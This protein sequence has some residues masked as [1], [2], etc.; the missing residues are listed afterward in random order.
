MSEGDDIQ[1]Q[2]SQGF[3]N[4]PSGPVTQNFNLTITEEQAK[5]LIAKL[6]QYSTPEPPPPNVL[7]DRNLFLPPGSRLRILPNAVFTGREEDLLSVG[8]TLL[9]GEGRAAGIVQAAAATGTGGIGKTQLAVEF[10]YRYGRYFQG[11]HWIQT[12]LDIKDEISTCGLAIGL[13]PWPEKI[14]EQVQATLLAWVV[15]GPR[16]IVLDNAEETDILEEWMPLLPQARLLLTSRRREWPADLGLDLHPLDTLPRQESLLLLRKLAPKLKKNPDEELDPVAKRLGD[17]PLALDLAGRY[18]HDRRRLTPADFL[19]EIEDEGALEHSALKDWTKHNPTQH[20]ANLAK[21]FLRSWEQI[22]RESARQLF[23]A[24]GYCAANTTIPWEVLVLSTGE[25]GNEAEREVDRDLKR[26]DDLGL[27]KLEETGVVVH[28]LLAEFGRLQDRAA[29]QSALPG[30]ADGLAKTAYDLNMSGL[31]DKYKPLRA[32]VEVAANWAERD[33][34]D[35]AGSLWVNSGFHLRAVA[36]Y[37]GARQAYERALRIDEDA[38]GPD[39]PNVATDVNNLGLVLKDQGDLAGARQTFERAL[40]I[41]EAAFGPD[42]PEV[43]TD[44]N[45]LGM[46]LQDLGDLAGARQAYERALAILEKFL[47]PDHPNIQIVKR[48]LNSLG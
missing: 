19:Q 17:L 24:C 15:S 45:N 8:K 23:Q 44:V 40:R 10:C 39:H 4:R 32:H 26:L 22:E 47:S 18:L 30:M 6:P 1:A 14:D 37:T 5:V 31:P 25:E 35:T 46:V 33:H 21:T 27:V 42:H 34:L 36:E 38:F 2:Y 29:E 20:E 12:N 28:P 3:I 13:Q 11:V 7:P 16:L 41:D 48:N 43:A 9:H